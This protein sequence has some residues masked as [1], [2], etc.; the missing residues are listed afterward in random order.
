MGNV[1]PYPRYLSREASL[2]S[3]R[4]PMKKYG[5]LCTHLGCKSAIKRTVHLLLCDAEMLLTRGSIRLVPPANKPFPHL[6]C[7]SPPS[8]P[9]PPRARKPLSSGS[10]ISAGWLCSSFTFLPLLRAIGHNDGI[11]L[12]LAF[13]R[14]NCSPLPAQPVLPSSPH[15]LRFGSLVP[16]R[17]SHFCIRPS[18]LAFL[19]ETLCD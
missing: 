9:P 17:Q 13:G 8:L 15:P 11:D 14:M 6:P 4:T 19:Y 12:S 5:L 16:S 3:H 2:H 10:C 1:H 18:G 7:S